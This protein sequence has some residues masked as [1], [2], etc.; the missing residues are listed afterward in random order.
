MYLTQRDAES[1]FSKVHFGEEIYETF[2]CTTDHFYTDHT[3]G[4]L[5][6]DLVRS[7]TYNTIRTNL[8]EIID[9]ELLN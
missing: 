6:W 9:Y 8:S 1:I 4:D 2:K 5:V 7:H 3:F